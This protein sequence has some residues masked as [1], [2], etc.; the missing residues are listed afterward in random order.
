ML[1][2]EILIVSDANFKKKVIK[3]IKKKIQNKNLAL[4]FISHDRNL[5]LQI[6]NAAVVLHNGHL[7][8]I[9][10]IKKAYNEYDKYSKI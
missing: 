9:I 3:T 10:P 8:K 7:G 1:A 4:I 2:D 5:N 6:C